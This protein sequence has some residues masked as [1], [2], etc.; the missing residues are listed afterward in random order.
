MNDVLPQKLRALFE[1]IRWVEIEDTALLMQ[2]LATGRYGDP[3]PCLIGY[4]DSSDVYERTYALHTLIQLDGARAI[5]IVI[6]LLN[7]PDRHFSFCYWIAKRGGTPLAIEP[8]LH[9]LQSR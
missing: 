6:P 7:N 9:I 1:A 2:E 3:F 4:L 8:V 5:P